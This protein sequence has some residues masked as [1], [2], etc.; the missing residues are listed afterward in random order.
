MID[1]NQH[2][3]TQIDHVTLRV[4]GAVGVTTGVQLETRVIVTGPHVT[5]HQVPLLPRLRVHTRTHAHTHN[6]HTLLQQM[7]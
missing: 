2:D 4:A 5:Q 1:V 6:L 3:M 7:F